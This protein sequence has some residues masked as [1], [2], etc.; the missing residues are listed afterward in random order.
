M[1]ISVQV[2]SFKS[3]KL[4]LIQIKPILLHVY[5]LK[6][7][8]KFSKSLTHEIQKQ[9]NIYQGLDQYVTQ[10]STVIFADADQCSSDDRRV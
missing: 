8:S 4:F 2:Y 1:T 3:L 7:F 10:I 6:A 9:I 5:P